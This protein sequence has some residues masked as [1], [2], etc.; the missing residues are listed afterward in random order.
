MLN[1]LHSLDQKLIL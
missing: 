1:E